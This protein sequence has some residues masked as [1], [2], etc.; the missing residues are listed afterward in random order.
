MALR[1]GDR[2][3]LLDQG[4]G[5]GEVGRLEGA[6]DARRIGIEGPARRLAEETLRL[7]A[8]ERRD[9][10][11]AGRALLGGEIHGDLLVPPSRFARRIQW[12]VASSSEIG[13]WS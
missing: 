8:G 6:L 11:P 9:A 3:D 2:G 1:L 7:G 10:A 4:Q 13:L 12:A 5:G